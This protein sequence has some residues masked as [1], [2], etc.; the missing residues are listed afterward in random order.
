VV[1]A[2][3]DLLPEGVPGECYNVAT[4]EARTLR[5]ALDVLVSLAAIPI[6]VRVDPA[7]LRPAD[8]PALEGGSAKLERL[9]GWKP[10]HRLED[11]LAE[12]LD[13]WRTRVASG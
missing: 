9:T 11:T 5:A 4:G 2:Y 8:P 1:R 7:K 10:E 12:V 6:E 3:Q 13:L